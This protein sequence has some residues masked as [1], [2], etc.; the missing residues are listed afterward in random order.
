M[1]AATRVSGGDAS[2]AAQWYMTE[3]LPTFGQ[4]TP[5]VLVSEGRAADVIK[6]VES[7]E[8]GPAG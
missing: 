8:A 6:Y 1:E 3:K 7:L 5:A 4:K 2:K